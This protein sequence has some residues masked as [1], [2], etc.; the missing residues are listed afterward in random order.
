MQEVNFA[1]LKNCMR[2]AAKGE[3]LTIGF[4]GGSITQGCAASEHERC[5]AYRVF[6]WWR[7]T[8]PKADMTYVNGGIGGTDSHFGVSRVWQD[9]LMYEPDVVVVDFSVNDM[10][11]DSARKE[12][13]FQETYEGL[14]RRILTSRSKPA[15]LILNNVYYSEGTNLQ[16]Q[17]NEIGAWYGIPHISM[18]DTLYKQMKAGH[19]TQE[20]LTPDGLH[21]SDKGHELV[22]AEICYL[23]EEVKH[24]ME[25]K[26]Q[27]CGLPQ[28]MTA[29]AYEN[30]KRLTIREASPVL[31]GFQIDADEK[32][33]HLDIFKN[34]WI[35]R[36]AGDRILFEEEAS[37]IA[38]QYRKSVAGPAHR[39]KVILD[40][41]TSH[42]WILDGKF[43]EDWG[44]SAQIA[45]ILH[46]GETKKHSVEIE[47]VDGQPDGAV[48][49]Y[50]MSL[51]L[52]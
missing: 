12:S 31:A 33:G 13:F 36:K 43:E 35:G 42:P 49:F 2:R 29:N 23:L 47:V 17:H 20:E 3:R 30:A 52:G 24:H 6:D 40:G 38:I 32:T 46:H 44:D 41:D 11:D 4:F 19:Y 21:P 8:F 7:R 16:Q 27:E 37:C 1:R 28:P 50:L 9:L 14:M 48:P 5:Y 18:K 26:E 45:V 25:E 15:V 34:G 39:V 10:T 22:A 51:I